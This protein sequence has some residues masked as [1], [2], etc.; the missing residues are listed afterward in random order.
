M[1]TVN[2]ITSKFHQSDKGPIV[3]VVEER[4]RL[5]GIRSRLQTKDGFMAISDWLL[6]IHRPIGFPTGTKM[7]DGKLHFESEGLCMPMQSQ[8]ACMGLLG[9][10][11]WHS[12]VVRRVTLSTHMSSMDFDLGYHRD[13]GEL[14][15]SSEYESAVR[16]LSERLSKW[17][18]GYLDVGY[19]LAQ[20]AAQDTQHQF[21]V[22]RV[23]ARGRGLGF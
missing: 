2:K 13:S 19:V 6:K 11:R 16:K 21:W 10:F 23:A 14:Y 7:G 22:S 5:G 1:T 3:Y 12:D 9:E 20:F 18:H 15:K 17:C 8:H 4:N